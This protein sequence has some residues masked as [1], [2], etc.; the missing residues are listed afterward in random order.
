MYSPSLSPITI[1][2]LRTSRTVNTTV[3]QEFTFLL[4]IFKMQGD[5]EKHEGGRGSLTDT[6]AHSAQYLAPSFPR[7]VLTRR[8]K[9]QNELTTCCLSNSTCFCCNKAGNTVDSIENQ[10]QPK[11]SSLLP[12]TLS[13]RPRAGT[14]WLGTRKWHCLWCSSCG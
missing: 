2:I 9:T 4:Y 1:V 14:Q 3:Y 6:K 13:I 10:T 8:R 7:P 12:I 11:E 5:K